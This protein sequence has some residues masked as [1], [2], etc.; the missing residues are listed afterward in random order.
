MTQPDSIDNLLYFYGKSVAGALE[1]A[2]HDTP[3]QTGGGGGTFGGMEA[4]VTAL[5]N[6]FEKMD[7]KLDKIL[8]ELSATRADVSFVKGRIETAP[9]SRDFGE[10]KGRVDS[11]PTM[12][13]IAA[14]LSMAT[15]V[16]VILNN[17]STIRAWFAG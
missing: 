11:L 3:L 4:R 6:Q 7:G 14:L 8:G 9:S 17:W 10:L 15:T 16:I 1:K 12:A 13:K 2:S 5:E